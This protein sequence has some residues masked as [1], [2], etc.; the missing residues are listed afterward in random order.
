MESK[1]RGYR[2]EAEQLSHLEC[3]AQDMQIMTDKQLA[4]DSG[5]SQTGEFGSKLKK[6]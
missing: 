4:V 5:G 6:E 3:D 2:K 1:Y